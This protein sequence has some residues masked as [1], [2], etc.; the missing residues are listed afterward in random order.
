MYCTNKSTGHGRILAA[1]I[2]SA[3]VAISLNIDASGLSLN[4]AEQL[5][6]REDPSVEVIEA[7]RL[8]LDELSAAAEQL[9]DPLL[10][11]GMVSLPTD[12]FNLGQEA[13]T[14]VQLGLVQKFPRGHT[15][16]LTS[17]QIRQRS[18]GL[19]DTIRDQKLQIIL[20]VREQFFEILKQQRLANINAEAIRV[21]ADLA[22]IIQDYYAT[23]QVHQQD[24]FQAVV[25]LAKV[26]ERAARIS[27]GKDQARARLATWIGNAAYRNLASDWPLLKT[28]SSTAVIK[29]RLPD[30]PRILALGKNIAATETD[31]ELAR[32]KYKPE[33]S[34]DLTY[35]GRGGRNPDGSSRSDLLSLMMVMDL[36]LFTNNRQDRVTASRLAK[37]SAARFTRDDVFRRM[38][39]EIDLHSATWQRQ[40]ER[41]D[42]FENTILPQAA[43]STE[44]SFEAYQSFFGDLTT[45]LR[46]QITEFELRL[47]HARLQ[48]EALKTNA[49]L[50]YLEG[51]FK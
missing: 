27:Q 42:L 31:V 32:E 25:E 37:S 26:E 45:L 15:R 51:E 16:S 8:A 24:V 19:D 35:G 6:L 41:I 4:D 23:G 21:F 22:D 13:M 43:F 20:A 5:A 28:Q 9:P 39:S 1:C 18:E 47:D 49:R 33:F 7:S 38:Q 50:L 48:A 3:G 44:A 36:P 12:T 10:K 14:Q 30:H 11:V 46:A 29:A 40:Q 34:F 17:R 2:A